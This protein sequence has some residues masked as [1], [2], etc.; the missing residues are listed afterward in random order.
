VL[1]HAENGWARPMDKYQVGERV[2]LFPKDGR[3]A[4][5]D[6]TVAAVVVATPPGRTPTYKVGPT[7]YM[8]RK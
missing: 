4:G 3:A 6:A 5:H 1:L 7:L 8:H 2:E